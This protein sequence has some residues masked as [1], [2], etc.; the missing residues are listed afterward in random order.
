MEHISP[1]EQISYQLDYT[2]LKKDLLDGTI[3]PKEARD[4]LITA[5]QST[6]DRKA[7]LSN[8]DFL[9]DSDIKNFIN[10][11]QEDIKKSY[12]QLLSLT[13]LHV[14]QT[15]LFEG[16]NEAGL[17]FWKQALAHEYEANAFPENIGYKRGTIA[18]LEKD[19][20]TLEDS[21]AQL[22]SKTRNC[23][24]LMNML[25]GLK[26]RGYPDYFSDYRK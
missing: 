25:K 4:K 19:I 8:L 13:E 6:G 24:I 26:E 20:G 3:S 7:A 15:N 22:D 23:Q 18:Y 2:T 5:D 1:V 14:G 10:N 12:Y 11:Q 21:I 16:K 17:Q 9:E